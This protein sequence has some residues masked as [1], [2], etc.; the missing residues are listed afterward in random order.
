MVVYFL[1]ILDG[2][3][4]EFAAK[5][6]K[7]LRMC[8]E[9][10]QNHFRSTQSTLFVGKEGQGMSR[11]INRNTL[12]QGETDY[13]TDKSE[14]VSKFWR[15]DSRRKLLE[16][17]GRIR[18]EQSSGR[19]GKIHP[20][21]ELVQGNLQLYVGKNANIGKAERDFAPGA[22]VYFVVSFNLHGPV[23]NGI[24]FSSQKPSHV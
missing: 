21:I 16:C 9:K 6:V 17:K 24:T 7:A 19:P 20:Y 10:S 22:L 5:Y 3:S 15:I 13:A 8:R 1:N 2:H 12:F 23:A 14:K 11:L 4:L 18:V